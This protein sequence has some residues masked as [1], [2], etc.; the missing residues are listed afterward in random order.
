[1]V[2]DLKHLFAITDEAGR[3]AGAGNFLAVK[4]LMNERKQLFD[5]IDIEKIST[6]ETHKRAIVE[7]LLN[8][9]KLDEGITKLVKQEMEQTKKDMIEITDKLKLLAAYSKKHTP[10]R[11]FDRVL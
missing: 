10:S 5:K 3:L 1:M 4:S 2:E 8:I 7:L 9:V 11:R 6:C